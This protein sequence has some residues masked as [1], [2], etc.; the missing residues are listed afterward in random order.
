VT[1]P[2]LRDMFMGPRNIFR[3]KEALL[4]ML[5]GD[6]YGKTPL[7]GQLLLFKS[8]YY[9]ISLLNFKRTLHAWRMRKQNIRVVDNS[10][11]PG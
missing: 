7:H 8:L 3:V 1:N 2:T 4:S 6:I 5:A 10:V 9:A 11:T